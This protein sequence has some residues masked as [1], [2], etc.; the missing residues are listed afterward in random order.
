[1]S[2]KPVRSVIIVG[3]GVTG[4]TAAAC[5]AHALRGQELKIT[6]LD[7]GSPDH[8]QAMASLPITLAFH[9]RL[10][11]DEALRA[12]TR[13]PAFASFQEHHVGTIE[14][15]KWADFTV[16]EIDPFV[17]AESDPAA[18]LKGRVL[19]TVVQGRIVYSSD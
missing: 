11:I 10:G 15:G 14:P 13:W 12:Y 16:L 5:I 19:M 4:W 6:V 3:G 7:D 8:L 2:S 18:I 9:Q 17:L 1:M